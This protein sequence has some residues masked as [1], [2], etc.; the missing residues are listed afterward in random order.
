MTESHM[1]VR[2]FVVPLSANIIKEVA[3]TWNISSKAAE[4]P[5]I[6][7]TNHWR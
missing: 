4:F 3:A 5:A 6:E 7:I 1:M 2:L